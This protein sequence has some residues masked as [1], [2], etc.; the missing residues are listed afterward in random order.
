[1]QINAKTIG[2]AIGGLLLAYGISRWFGFGL[3]DFLISQRAELD[4]LYSEPKEL[5]EQCRT[6]GRAWEIAK[7]MAE[8]VGIGPARTKNEKGLSWVTCLNCC[9]LGEKYDKDTDECICFPFIHCEPGDGNSEACN[10]CCKAVRP[11]GASSGTKRFK[12][13]G[14]CVC[15]WSGLKL[16]DIDQMSE[17]ASQIA[18]PNEP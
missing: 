16:E 14:P 1:M 3:E 8:R 7:R 4:P 10:A 13:S 12:K 2:L 9:P 5:I 15:W 11:P 18:L 6:K 17:A